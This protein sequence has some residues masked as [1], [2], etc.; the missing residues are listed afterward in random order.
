MSMDN[1]DYSMKTICPF[2]NKNKADIND[3]SVSIEKI[4]SMRKLISSVC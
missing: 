4:L 3:R 2:V 1:H